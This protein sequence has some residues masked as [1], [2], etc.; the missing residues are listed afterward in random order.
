MGRTVEVAPVD[1]L[2]AAAALAAHA[3]GEVPAQ[4]VGFAAFGVA[5]AK[6]ADDRACALQ[7][8]RAISRD[9]SPN[10]LPYVCGMAFDCAR[11]PGGVWAGVPAARWVLPRAM[12]W[13]R[14]GRCFVEGDQ[15]WL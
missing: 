4:D 2:G 15:A 11:A 7:L 5:E 9:R 12:L 8:L 6:Q 13:R 1:V 10:A 14:G 3:Y